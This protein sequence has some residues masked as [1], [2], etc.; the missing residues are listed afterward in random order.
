MA[1]EASFTIAAADFPLS[2]VFEQ[3]TDATIE[4]DR[5][6]PTSN[7][8]IPYFWIYADDLTSLTTDLSD[9]TGID[10]VKIIDEVEGDAFVRV[11]WNLQHESILTAITNTDVTL[12]SGIGNNER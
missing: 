6:V 5:V 12:L 3:L 2:A 7:A 9:D 10:D 11:D 8:V 1:I 4:L